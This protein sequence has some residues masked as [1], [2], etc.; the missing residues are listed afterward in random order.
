MD[1]RKA[2]IILENKMYSD[3]FYLE[4][5]NVQGDTIS[6]YIFNL[7]FQILIFKLNFELQ[8]DDLIDFPVPPASSPPLPDT[9]STYRRK[10]YAYADDANVLVKLD[11]D[12]LLVIKNILERFGTMSGLACNIDKTILLPVGPQAHVD[13]RISDIGFTITD[14]VTILG[15]QI[16]GNGACMENFAS[17]NTKIILITRHWAPFALS[18][19]GRINIAKS[20]MYGQL[21]Y[22]GCFLPIPQDCVS[23]I[24][25]TVYNKFCQ[26]KS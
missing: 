11:Y 4:H 2:C 10:V 16:V 14:K 9:V 18:L 3:F 20:M 25:G 17:L 26:R 7:G 24:D 6:P 5:G 12:T 23:E 19:P 21:N 22:L 13:P 1:N 8:D 15:L